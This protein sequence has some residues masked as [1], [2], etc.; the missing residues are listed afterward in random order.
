MEE[1]QLHSWQVHNVVGYYHV[2]TNE[3]H[4]IM[5]AQLVNRSSTLENEIA[6]E[7]GCCGGRHNRHIIAKK[8]AELKHVREVYAEICVRS[9]ASKPNGVIG[10]SDN[11]FY[12]GFESYDDSLAG[13]LS[14]PSVLSNSST[15]ACVEQAVFSSSAAGAFTDGNRS[16]GE[17]ESCRGESYVSS[18]AFYS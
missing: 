7:N 12:S 4:V 14:H 6:M 5:K 3:A 11:L 2:E 9:Q 10:R 17:G 1:E 18:H 8:V 13:W 16:G 15:G